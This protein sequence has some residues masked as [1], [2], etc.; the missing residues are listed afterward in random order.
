M[1][2]RLKNNYFVVVRLALM[3]ILSVS[4]IIGMYMKNEKIMIDKSGV[5]LEILLLV[6]LYIGL[7]SV[8]EIC[9]LNKKRMIIIPSILLFLVIFKI[10]GD[11][12]IL[13]GYFTAYEAL[14][15]FPSV[16][17]VWYILLIFLAFIPVS[18][19]FMTRFLVV[20]LLSTIYIQHEFIVLSYQKRMMED[21][22]LEQGLKR[23]MRDREHQAKAEV[24]RSMLQAENQILEERASLSQ[25]LHDKLGHNINGSIYQLEGAKVL[26]DKD[27][28]KTRS[29]IQAVIDQLRT[30][31][32]EIRA[33]L[34]K[35]R[36]KKNEYAMVQ[37]YN[38]CEDS[39]NKGVETELSIDGDTSVIPDDVWEIILDNTYEAVS[40]SMKYARCKHIDIKI[41]VMNKMLRCLVS[42]DGIG[43]KSIEDGMGISGMRQR[44]RTVG[45]TISFET[46]AGFT[47]NML[48]PLSEE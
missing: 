44:I 10:G 33:I 20:L 14:T 16:G 34:R 45:G 2:E 42:D 27:P 9:S 47:V 48:I 15:L 4:G 46:E 25:T 1:N 21:L 11:S 23:D 17:F 37:L 31:M 19:D 30:G 43:C 38:L 40:N 6:S 18:M 3:L 36:P 29:M 24:R 5:S 39:N 22:V 35:E 7:M 8:K 12:F 28:E 26:M 32:D 13:L 41:V